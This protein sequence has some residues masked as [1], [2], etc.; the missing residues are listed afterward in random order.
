MENKRQ[1]VAAV[2]VT[3]NRMGLLAECLKSLEAQ[4]HR[5]DGIIVVNNA[6]T[7]GTIDYLM[8]LDPQ[9]YHVYHL[10]NN[11]GG[12]GG[13]HEG[14]KRSV[15][16][17]FDYS[18]IMDDDAVPTLAALENLVSSAGVIKWDFGFLTSKVES[19]SGEVMNVPSVDQRVNA[20]G[21]PDW[22]KFSQFGLFKVSSATFVSVLIP[23]PII[24]K[25]GLP[26]KEMFIWGDD[27]EY[28]QR[29]S[30]VKESYFVGSSAVIHK[31]VL[32]SSLSLS[33]EENKGRIK[34]YFFYYR[35]NAFNNRV[36]WRA[37]TSMR[38]VYTTG[39]ELVKILFS[40]KGLKLFRMAVLIRGVISSL[41]FRPKIEFP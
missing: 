13:F 10:K 21:Y 4:K 28:T 9:F 23:N 32:K 39:L 12:A 20:L 2:V 7:D 26:L 41:W 33:E 19:H 30:K 22:A 34:L 14:L 36:Y 25:V 38:F 15:E 3:Y 35:N 5:L 24:E 40:K 37:S 27:S 18:W 29:I 11:T 8:S 1:T 31:R 17:G 16:L 6:S